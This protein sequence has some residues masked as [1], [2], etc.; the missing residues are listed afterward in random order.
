MSLGPEQV[1]EQ[2]VMWGSWGARPLRVMGGSKAWGLQG[3]HGVLPR[4]Q[5]SPRW[6]GRL[7]GPTDPPSNPGSALSVWVALSKYLT[8]LSLCFLI[9]EG[10]NEFSSEVL[11]SFCLM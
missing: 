6:R 5:H 8:S 10:V 4:A 7:W 9:I 3:R 1:D 2:G 11:R